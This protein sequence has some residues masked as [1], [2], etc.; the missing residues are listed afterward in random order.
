VTAINRRAAAL[1]GAVALFVHAPLRAQVPSWSLEAQ[2]RLI[3]GAGSDAVREGAVLQKLAEEGESALSRGDTTAAERVFDNAARMVHSPDIEMGLVRTYMQAGDYRRAVSF[4]SHAAGAH[5]NVPGG[6]A[7]HGWL[8]HIGGQTAAARRYLSDALAQFPEDE[9]L[10]LTLAMLAAPQPLPGPALMVPPLRVAP[11]AVPA[12]ATPQGTH[13]AGTALLLGDG[14]MAIV[15]AATVRGARQ[16]WVRNGLGQ[17][18]EAEW[19]RGSR[20]E[21]A[22]PAAPVVLKLASPLPAVPWLQAPPREPFA[23]SPSYTVEYVPAPDAAATWPLL[24]QGFFG[25]LLPAPGE[26]LLGISLAPGPR[27]GPV[28]DAFGRLAGMGVPGAD[29]RDRLVPIE[30]LLRLAS[31]P[32]LAV[33][34]AAAA[35]SA[36]RPADRAPVDGLYEVGMRLALQVLVSP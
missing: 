21:L 18:V 2:R 25:Q 28:F 26:R 1:A 31:L 7:L 27:G 30:G 32:A 9:S 34:D 16:L 13:V 15:P 22:A 3:G 8:L 23:G 19:S 11:Y 20:S 36:A 33:P 12:A 24:K 17:T 10:R 5:R 29:G 35:A 6:T 14:S 4:G